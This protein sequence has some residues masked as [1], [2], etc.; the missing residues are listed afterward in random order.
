MSPP[1]IS[2]RED[3]ISD[4]R[5]KKNPLERRVQNNHFAARCKRAE[6]GIM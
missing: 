4:Y 3:S 5:E 2:A 6:A 1:E